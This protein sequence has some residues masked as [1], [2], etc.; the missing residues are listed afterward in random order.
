MK[1]VDR[2]QANLYL[3]K[4]RGF[5]ADAE[6]MASLSA[7]SG[8]GVAV[9]AI[10]A[11]ITFADAVTIRTQEVKSASGDH[12]DAVDVLQSSLGQLTDSDRAALKDLRYILQR[13]DDASYTANHVS[14]HEADL[15]V[16]KLRSFASWAETR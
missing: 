10:H 6:N 1:R 4:A 15:I 8:N 16:S 3:E 9:V 11:A 5:L 7:F 2:T 14:A 12:T 13:K